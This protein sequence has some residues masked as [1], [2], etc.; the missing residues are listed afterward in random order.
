MISR[1]ELAGVALLVV[2]GVA[3]IALAPVKRPAAVY[4]RDQ[5]GQ[6]S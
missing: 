3:F 6:I 1:G 5:V 2:V 4:T